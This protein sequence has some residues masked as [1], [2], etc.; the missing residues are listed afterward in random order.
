MTVRIQ[1][2]EP[3]KHE[4]RQNVDRS[5]RTV[6]QAGVERHYTVVTVSPNTFGCGSVDP[7]EL[8][9]PST[10]TAIIPKLSHLKLSQ[11]RNCPSN[12]V[13][14][15][16]VWRRYAWDSFGTVETTF[17]IEKPPSGTVSGLWSPGQVRT[18]EESS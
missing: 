5:H 11:S 6:G 3:R 17:L 1:G 9:S 13:Q 12:T 14:N 16:R 2:S 18:D 10:C 8:S 7:V 4:G 15:G